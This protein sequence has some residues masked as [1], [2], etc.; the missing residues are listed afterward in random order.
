MMIQQVAKSRGDLSS[1]S[2]QEVSAGRFDFSE[3]WSDFR[4]LRNDI[5]DGSLGHFRQAPLDPLRHHPSCS[6]QGHHIREITTNNSN[7][8]NPPFCA[9]AQLD[10]CLSYDDPA[11]IM[12]RVKRK[13]PCQVPWENR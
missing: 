8:I 9:K 4:N 11:D 10:D 3:S 12:W 6:A 7:R 13:L 2:P 1:F 5:I